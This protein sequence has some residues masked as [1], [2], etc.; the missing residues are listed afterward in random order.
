MTQ[1]GQFIG[2]EGTDGSGKSVQFRKLV[3]RLRKAGKKVATLDFPQYKK[4]SS[5]FVREYL[6][7]RYGGWK[8]VGPYRA[9]LFYALDRFDISP[10]VRTWLEEGRI[11]V[12]NRYVASNMGHQGAKVRNRKE[13]RKYFKW[14]HELEYGILGIPRPSTTIILH[15]PADV[16]HKLIG[17]KGAREYI[18][19]VKRDIHEADIEHLKE[20]ERTYL[21]MAKMFPKEFTVIECTKNGNML[22]RQDIHEK[23]WKVISRKVIA[24]R[25]K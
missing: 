9:S 22:S 12:T 6:N 2:I 23:I 10:Q 5:F 14:L 3:A 16:A 7:G 8:E 20:A 17:R 19:G 21:E 1:F 25:R 24:K 11:V 18:K 4:E 13:R 15:V